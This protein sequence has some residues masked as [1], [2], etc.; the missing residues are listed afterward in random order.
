MPELAEVEF[1]RKQWNPGLR[2]VIQEII[3]NKKARV[4]RNQNPE[5]IK[6]LI[7]GSRLNSSSAA[8]KQMVFLFNKNIWLGIH[9]GMTG[10]LE[11]RPP[12]QKSVKHDQLILK[13]NTGR[14]LVFND[15]RQFGLVQI[16][17]GE[18]V[19]PWW[20]KLPPAILSRNF[21]E[22]DVTDFLKRK[23]NS[24]IKAVL[25]MQEKF[26][27]IGNWM[28][29]EILWR[30]G[31]HPSA[32][33]GNFGRRSIH[34][35]YHKIKEVCRDAYRVIGKNWSDPPNSWLFNHRW[36][37]GG[38]CPK[39]KVLLERKTIGGRTSCWSPAKQK[40]GAERR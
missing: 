15:P 11:N 3:I 8:A 20:A 22:K 7:K 2:K 16:Y 13:T 35:L 32:R 31:F 38:R 5:K 19:P 24:P 17:Q 34:H 40:L 6:K 25:L 23:K 4:F 10:R 39:T 30:A 12:N 33:A 9:L 21:K 37:K 18:G 14:Q 26:P 27:G 28:A 1:F 29:D 36:E